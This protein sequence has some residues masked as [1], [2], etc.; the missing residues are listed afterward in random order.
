MSDECTFDVSTI[1]VSKTD[2]DGR[3]TYANDYFKKI[4]G[5]D[6]K[7]LIGLPHNLIRHPDMPRIIFKTLWDFIKNGQEINAYV[8]NLTKNGDYYWVYANVTPSFDLNK[9]IIGYHSTRRSPDKK[10]LE[11]IIPLYKELCS[12]EGSSDMSK[13]EGELNR[14]LTEKGVSYEEFIFAL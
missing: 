2:M 4:T 13:S 14:I 9:K 8:I 3:I 6:E 7:E 11:T 12:L 5:Y 10:A 1:L